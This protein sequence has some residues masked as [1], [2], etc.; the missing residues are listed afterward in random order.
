MPVLQGVSDINDYPYRSRRYV[1][2]SEVSADDIDEFALARDWPHVHENPRDRDGGIDGQ[3]IW[4]GLPDVALHFVVDATSGVAYAVFTGASESATDPVRR[5]FLDE[6]PLW[7][8][9]ELFEAFDSAEDER[10]R[11]QHALRI[12]FAAAAEF[13]DEVF[14]RIVE[15][16][17]DDDPRVRYAGIWAATYTGYRQFVPALRRVSL[18]DPEDFVRSRAISVVRAFES[19]GGR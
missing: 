2:R 14:R 3:L 4:Q 7:A 18:E 9:D 11:A 10:V 1:L 5:Q 19:E 16:I 6:V 17:G 13:D 15:T 12:G 8:L